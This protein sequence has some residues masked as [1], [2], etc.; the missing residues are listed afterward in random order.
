[1]AIAN[2]R[3]CSLK[4]LKKRDPRERQDG[5]REDQQEGGDPD[6]RRDQQAERQ[7]RSSASDAFPLPVF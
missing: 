5:D 3:G 7:P 6:D 1:M 4:L 2:H